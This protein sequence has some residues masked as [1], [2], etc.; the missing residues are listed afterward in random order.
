MI[1]SINNRCGSP[2]IG[3][4]RFLSFPIKILIRRRFKMRILFLSGLLLSLLLTSCDSQGPSQ[5]SPQKTAPPAPTPT[6]MKLPAIDNLAAAKCWVHDNGAVYG[7]FYGNKSCT[8][9]ARL[10]TNAPGYGMDSSNN[11]GFGGLEYIKIQMQKGNSFSL[12][13]DAEGSVKPCDNLVLFRKG[14]DPIGH[15]AVVF[16]VDRQND[17]LF[18]LD[19]NFTGQGVALRALDINVDGKNAYVIPSTCRKTIDFEKCGPMIEAQTITI[20]KT[21]PGIQTAST[22]NRLSIAGWELVYDPE[23]WQPHEEP[24]NNPM[25]SWNDCSNSLTNRKEENCILGASLSEGVT[26]NLRLEESTK[27]YSGRKVETVTYLD[28]N[29]NNIV[30]VAF[31]NPD[32]FPDSRIGIR[33]GNPKI[34]TTCIEKIEKILQDSLMQ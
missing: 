5:S 19:Q 20:T 8:A 26:D 15:T 13:E 11:R 28:I 7:E 30:H 27:E 33:W 1:D 25:C 22:K 14:D 2:E 10:L 18:Y 17:T 23:E 3:F 24:T 12:L 6:E 4:F 32:N 31:Y 9:L 34:S 16:S 29:T 21:A